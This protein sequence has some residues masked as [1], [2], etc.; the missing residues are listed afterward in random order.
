MGRIG[1][2]GMVGGSDG[3]RGSGYSATEMG[4][5]GQAT[6]NKRD[7]LILKEIGCMN[8][9]GMWCIGCRCCREKA[10]EVTMWWL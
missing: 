2:F 7:V 3:G 6:K 1:V 10:S 9:F 8:L 5:K 4:A